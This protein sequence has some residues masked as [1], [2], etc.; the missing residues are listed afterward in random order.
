MKIKTK[1]CGIIYL[2]IVLF[3][4]S[5][6]GLSFHLHTL[7]SKSINNILK[8]RN[9]LEIL[10]QL[11]LALARVVMPAN[12]YL[13]H[14]DVDERYAFEDL[15]ANVN[16]HFS[17]LSGEYLPTRIMTE[18]REFINKLKVRYTRVKAFSEKILNLPDPIGNAEGA[19]LM[20]EMDLLIDNIIEDM[21]EL[22]RLSRWD[23]LVEVEVIDTHFHRYM[24]IVLSVLGAAVIVSFLYGLFLTKGIIV[25]I[26]RLVEYMGF[27]ARGDFSRGWDVKRKDEIGLLYNSF[28]NM[29]EDLQKTTVSK[30]YVDNIIKNMKDT[31]II[32]SPNATIQIV[33]QST[34]NLLGYSE[35]ELIGEP[36]GMIFAE[37]I[38]FKRTGNGELIIN[39]SVVS[40]ENTYLSKDGRKIP[41]LFSSSIMRDNDGKIQEII[42]TALDITE[43]KQFEEA[44]R[45]NEAKYRQVHATSFDSIIIASAEG[46]ITE[47]NQRAEQIFGYKAGELVGLGL[48]KLIPERLREQH[49]NGLRRFLETGKSKIQGTIVELEGLRKNGEAFPVELTVNSFVVKNNIYFTGTVRDITERNQAEKERRKLE[50]HYREVIENIFKFMPEGLLVFTDKLSLFK[51][52]K[53][54]QDIVKIYSKSLN[55]SEE[56][57][58][59]IIIEQVKN[60]ITNKDNTE[61][62]ISKKQG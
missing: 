56:E 43:R 4:I 27:V 46:K 39:V 11:D 34:C 8:Y 29:T 35:E 62:R 17:M 61:I 16:K 59:E 24:I 48:I 36:I 2:F 28:N 45:E 49:L 21:K 38:I 57:L 12:D 25:P 32:V 19:R 30:D 7:T 18:R 54:F 14:G 13:I 53:A 6:L 47:A 33:N 50:K 1:F 9:E 22:H 58:A 37:D 60:K 5:I 20:E 44:L 31:L 15:D 40:M 51:K 52:N 26:E 55:Y 10:S 3:V 42:C 23:A 41:V